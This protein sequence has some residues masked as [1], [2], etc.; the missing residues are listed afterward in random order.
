MF[1][2]LNRAKKEEERNLYLTF[3]ETRMR[4]NICIIKTCSDKLLEK[5]DHK[6][7]KP[8]YPAIVA[9]KDEFGYSLMRLYND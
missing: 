2:R 1:D 5:I 9:V 7:S 6:K 8:D 4:E 3:Q